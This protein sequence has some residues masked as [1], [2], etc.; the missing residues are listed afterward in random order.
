MPT[1]GVFLSGYFAMEKTIAEMALM[2]FQKIVQLV[3]KR[4]I[5]SAKIDDVCQ[6]KITIFFIIV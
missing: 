4:E 1:I 3:K 2:S 6:G 5:S